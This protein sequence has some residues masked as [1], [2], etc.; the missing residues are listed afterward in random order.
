M[1]YLNNVITVDETW[2]YCY[3][4][5]F[6]RQMSKWVPRGSSR[7]LKS[8]VTKSKIKCMVITFFSREGFVYTHTLPDGWIGT[9]KS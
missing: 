6:K 3:C 9:S 4:P 2:I 5:A 1:D 8:H 7:L